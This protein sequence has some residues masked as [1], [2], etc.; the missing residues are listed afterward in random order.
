MRPEDR[1]RENIDAMLAEAGW[2]VQDR[3]RLNLSAGR[4]VALRYFAMSQGEA[5]YLLFVDGE[6]AGTIEAKKEGV[7]LI[8]VEEQSAKYR[9]GLAESFPGARHPLPFSY[10]TTGIE[11]RFTSHLDPEPRSRSVFHFHRPTTLA[12]W[13]EQA[14]EGVPNEQNQTLRACLTRLPPLLP[15]GLCDCQV[16]A[17]TK[18]ERSFA[19]NKPRALI[20]MTM[21][22]GKT[23]MAVSSIY[24]LIKHGGAQR[25]LFLVDRSNL[26]RQTLNEFLQY[27]TP[28]D[29]RKFT[30]LYN[31]QHLKSNTIDTVSRVCITTIQRLYSILCG[32]PELDPQEEERSLFGDEDDIDSQPPKEVRYNPA[33]PIETFDI[34]VVD[35]CHR[36][37]YNKWRSVLEY[38]DASIVG[39]TATPSKQ[40]FSFF[41]KNLVMEYGHERAVADG[42]NVDY[43][44]YTIRTQITASGS[45]VERGFQ[46]GR[47]NRQTRARRWET[48]SGDLTYS[49][50]QLDRDVVAPDQIRTIIRAFRE[51]LFTDLFPGRREVPKTLVFAKDDN[52]AEEIV[53]IVR[54]EFD[55]GNEFAQKITYKTTGYKPEDL[56]SAFRNSYYPRIAVTVD[57]I[58]TGTDIKALEVLLFMRPVRSQGF[59]EQMKGRGTRTIA[60]DDFQT[61]TSDAFGKTH[62]V[63]VD[64]VGVYDQFKNDDPQLERKKSVPFKKVLDDVA[65][66]RWTRDTDLLYT[67]AGRLGRLAKHV[68]PGEEEK[69]RAAS[70]GLT[71]RE[72]ARSLVDALDP[73]KQVE[74]A[75]VA[76][77]LDADALAYTEPDTQAIKA[78]AKR[79]IREA[80]APFDNPTLRDALTQAQQ[81]EEL[82]ID[83]VSQDTL[84]NSG[85]HVQA[86][87]QALRTITTFKQYMEQHHDE[88]TALQVFYN[89]PYRARL[90][91]EDVRQLADAIA[92]PPLGLSTS[93]LW[94]AYETLHRTREAGGNNIKR[95]LTD[96]VSLVRYT[97]VYD[98][99]NRD[100][101]DNQDE[102]ALL[103]PFG[104]TV[105]RRFAAWLE[106]QE[107]TRGKPFTAEQRQWLEY[108]RDT[109]ATSLT[110][111]PEDFEGVPFNQHGGYGKAYQLFGAEL[112]A[113][114]QQ[115]NER[116]A[117]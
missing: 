73:D 60:D 66:H 97:M 85:M 35:E 95:P 58:S 21:G 78:A 42:V 51:A 103:E 89:R 100:T 5:D 75:Q 79:L 102:T 19:L 48:L 57:M 111:E 29:G 28:D 12:A 53:Q 93:K 26:A 67:L 110:I 36:S 101:Q 105:H 16:E 104:E 112:P 9:M 41:N 32:E 7:P 14:P 15:A 76:L 70:G 52:H 59:F 115:L 86:E 62:F 47:R 84:L 18:L 30:E 25:I 34:I 31:V 99:D 50:S 11:T 13:L 61:V 56:I 4:G 46:V 77:G 88:I 82:I 107:R 109:I 81:R 1:A 54:E 27:Q 113:I 116:L 72:L 83:E 68:T 23:F 92:L 87:Q 37:I 108:M 117:A 64:A 2:I 20:Q 24:R 43:Q 6:P 96:L 80:A 90:R 49:A 98:Q 106:E 94:Q 38:F 44:V 69:I 74:A 55:R 39:L 3:Q 63:L 22:S 71:V 65:L 8:G 45:T 17:I 10:E 91:Y 114:I 33:V 40:T